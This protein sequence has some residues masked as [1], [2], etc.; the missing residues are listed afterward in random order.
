MEVLLNLLT[1]SSFGLD[2]L[3]IMDTLHGVLCGFLHTSDIKN[4]GGGESLASMKPCG[5]FS[6]HIRIGH[7]AHIT[8]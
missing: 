5:G 4:G 6:N 7:R 3:T 8:I 2:L 1:H